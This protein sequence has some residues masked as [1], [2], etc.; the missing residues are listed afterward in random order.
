MGTSS[1]CRSRPRRAPD[2]NLLG[3]PNLRASP[4]GVRRGPCRAASPCFTLSGREVMSGCAQRQKYCYIP[5]PIFIKHGTPLPHKTGHALPHSAPRF[6]SSPMATPHSAGP[7]K[8]GLDRGFAPQGPLHQAA[9]RRIH[10]IHGIVHA[11]TSFHR[12]L[13]RAFHAGCGVGGTYDSRVDWATNP[14]YRHR[15]DR[16]DGD[17]VRSIHGHGEPC[18]RRAATAG[19]A[20]PVRSGP[21]GIS[22][23]PTGRSACRIQI[24]GRGY[25]FIWAIH[26]V[27]RAH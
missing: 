2:L 12:T 1:E 10:S 7:G 11:V 4:E 23:S 8:G 21:R 26:D 16:P 15:T 22:R 24:S 19:Y 20:Y 9:A 27:H 25:S 17:S 18:F 14:G 6:S 3:G 13:A 5:V